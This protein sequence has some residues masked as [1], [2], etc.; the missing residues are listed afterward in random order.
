MVVIRIVRS[1]F[2]FPPPSCGVFGSLSDPPLSSLAALT[3]ELTT[4]VIVFVR[5]GVI[6]AKTFSARA[7]V[8]A[9]SAG[10]SSFGS[11]PFGSSPLGSSFGSS[12]VFG[13][14]AAGVSAVWNIVLQLRK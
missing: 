3:A 7:S 8:S 2:W 5:V 12:S 14:G 6:L 10:T 1:N 9:S 11:S 4:S 13:A